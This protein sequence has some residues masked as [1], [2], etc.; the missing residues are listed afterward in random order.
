MGGGGHKWEASRGADRQNVDDQ[1]K[2]GSISLS[3]GRFRTL[4]SPGLAFNAVMPRIGKR[5]G[6]SCVQRI[7][8]KTALEWSCR[9]FSGS[10]RL[11]EPGPTWR[12]QC[13]PGGV[14]WAPPSSIAAR[15]GQREADLERYGAAGGER[16]N[17]TALS[18][19][20]FVSSDF[21]ASHAC[22]ESGSW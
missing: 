1:A 15:Y 12:S 4:S 11:R 13:T 5:V 8:R 22:T 20:F 2:T 7:G 21:E 9:I 6:R 17:T 14:P 3:V 18:V 19:S 10:R 16:M